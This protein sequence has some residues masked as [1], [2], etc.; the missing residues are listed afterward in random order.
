MGYWQRGVLRWKLEKLWLPKKAVILKSIIK[1]NGTL[2]YYDGNVKVVFDD[3]TEEDFVRGFDKNIL[4]FPDG[5]FKVDIRE[6]VEDSNYQK[7]LYTIRGNIK[8]TL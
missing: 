7:I 4:I 6:A 5:S 2:R 8:N 3:N 1:K